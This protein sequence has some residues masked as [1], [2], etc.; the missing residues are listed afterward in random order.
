MEAVVYI[1][2]PDQEEKHC[3][4][5]D[6]CHL[7]IVSGFHDKFVIHSEVGRKTVVSQ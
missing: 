3:S 6:V 5:S 4:I 1:K 7:W 2:E